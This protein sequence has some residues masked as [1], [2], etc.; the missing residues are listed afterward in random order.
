M[1]YKPEQ[2]T[3]STNIM[4]NE[5]QITDP[6]YKNRAVLHTALVKAIAETQD[7]VADSTNPFHKNKY[8]SLNAH[9]S[10][11]KPIFAKH[12]LAVVQFPSSD[13]KS[14]GVTTTII[15]EC[16]SQLMD[17]IHI[18]VSDSITGQQAGAIISYLRRY[19]LASVAGIATEDDDAE[20]DRIQRAPSGSSK[21]QS[22]ANHVVRVSN[23]SSTGTLGTVNFELPVPFG[24]AKGTKLNELPLKNTDRSLK[25]AD[26]SYWAKVWTPKP[27]GTSTKISQRDLDFKASAQALYAMKNAESNGDTTPKFEPAQEETQ[28]EIPF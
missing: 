26:L 18:P 22:I 6:Y 9:L 5:N 23:E 15:H 25:C 2:Y 14:I 4:N 17:S 8:A 21:P 24:D 16:G 19:A 1:K 12:G 11:V 3:S 20:T 10:V 27:F 13:E 28:D 7:V